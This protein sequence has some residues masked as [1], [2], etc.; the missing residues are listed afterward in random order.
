MKSLFMAVALAVSVTGIGAAPDASAQSYGY[1]GRHHDRDWRDG[2]HD[3]RGWD[4]RRGWSDRRHWNRGRNGWRNHR[5]C[6][7]EWRHHHRV[8]RCW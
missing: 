7:W 8:R 3:R 1:S 5:R 6:H 4:R 2:R